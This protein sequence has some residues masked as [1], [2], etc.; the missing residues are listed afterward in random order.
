MFSSENKQ[1]CLY[2]VATPVGN[3]EDI[4]LRAKNVLG[5]VDLIAAE[6]TRNTRKLL[7]H[8]EIKPCPIQSYHDHKEEIQ[9]QKLIEGML[10]DSSHVALVS[11][12]GTPCIS[13][14]G[15]RIVRMVGYRVLG[16]G[17]NENDIE[18]PGTST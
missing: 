18:R 14:P 2:I 13:D 15:Y 7:G 8:L 3:L 6:D 12:A 11:D 9:A 16:Y 4:S 17:G 10:R 5:K 1:P